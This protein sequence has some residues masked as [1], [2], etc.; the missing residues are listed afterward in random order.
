[1]DDGQKL[2]EKLWQKP[3]SAK[4]A[5]TLVET[6]FCQDGLNRFKSRLNL[7][8][9]QCWQKLANTVENSKELN[10]NICRWEEAVDWKW[11]TVS[12]KCNLCYRWRNNEQ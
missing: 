1:M 6:C 8:L 10:M 3:V 9:N 5:E 2:A 12:D 7:G 4:V 11:E